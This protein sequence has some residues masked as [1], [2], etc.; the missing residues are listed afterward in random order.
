MRSF[1]KFFNETNDRDLAYDN[2]ANK[3]Y[4]RSISD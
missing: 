3:N 4:A 1:S 2:M